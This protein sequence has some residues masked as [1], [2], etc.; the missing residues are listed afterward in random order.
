[1]P[2][3]RY[4]MTHWN[5]CSCGTQFFFLSFSSWRFKDEITILSIIK[6]I[7]SH[8]HRHPI[9]IGISKNILNRNSYPNI[10]VL[11]PVISHSIRISVTCV[12]HWKQI[13][14][15]SLLGRV[16]VEYAMHWDNSFFIHNTF[17]P[18]QKRWERHKKVGC[19]T[20]GIFLFCTDNT[21]EKRCQGECMISLGRNSSKMTSSDSLPYIYVYLKKVGK[22]TETFLRLYSIE[23]D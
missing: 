10:S 12:T 11:T 22:Q 20:L 3:I 7:L 5:M 21:Y 13:I 1:M 15:R 6:T 14:I 4:H 23:S 8:S 17:I 19:Y 18:T 9:I 2:W 16:A